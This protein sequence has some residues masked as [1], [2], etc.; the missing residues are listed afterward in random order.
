MSANGSNLQAVPSRH[1]ADPPRVRI[2]TLRGGEPKLHSERRSV[3]IVSQVNVVE[4]K[5]LNYLKLSFQ[6]LER[7]N[8]GET[9]YFHFYCIE[10]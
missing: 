9:S 7:F 10:G 2:E 4:A 5:I 8:K 1:L 6:R 3:V